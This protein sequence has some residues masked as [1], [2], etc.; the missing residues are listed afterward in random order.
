MME[1]SQHLDVSRLSSGLYSKTVCVF[2][3]NNLSKLATG[4]TEFWQVT[5][6]WFNH[7]R[8]NSKSLITFLKFMLCKHSLIVR[9]ACKSVILTEPLCAIERPKNHSLQKVR[10]LH[11]TCFLV[12]QKSLSSVSNAPYV[13]DRPKS[14]AAQA[15]MNLLMLL[16]IF[17]VTL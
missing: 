3:I 5:I 12:S 17:C 8:V 7:S 11:L 2:L 1:A 9:Q 14:S 10:K 6:G 13:N 4:L 15:T 16:T